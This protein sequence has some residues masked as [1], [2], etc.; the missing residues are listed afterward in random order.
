MLGRVDI[1]S[2]TGQDSRPRFPLREKFI[3]TFKYETAQELEFQRLAVQLPASWKQ[4]FPPGHQLNDIFSD[5]TAAIAHTDFKTMKK[6]FWRDVNFILYWLDPIM[7]KLLCL[8]SELTPLQEVCRLG[9]I[10]FTGPIRRNCGKLGV[11][12]TVYVRKLKDLFLATQDKIDWTPHT[13]LLLWVLFFGMLETWRLPEQC[14]YV[15]SLC[16]TARGLGLD[17]WAEVVESVSNFLWMENI[18][19]TDL[20]RFQNIVTLG[21][22]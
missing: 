10:L 12:S 21:F 19:E 20:D 4:I 16:L 7:H 22:N 13:Q 14:W 11:D 1:S 6:E 9:I 8:R 15:S 2:A 5:L 18:F 17:S 3:Q